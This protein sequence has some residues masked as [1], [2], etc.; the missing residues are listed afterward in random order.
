MTELQMFLEGNGVSHKQ[1]LLRT[2]YLLNESSD[3]TIRALYCI[4]EMRAQIDEVHSLLENDAEFIRAASK[5]MEAA[6]QWLAKGAQAVAKA[7]PM[8]GSVAGG[9]GGA[10]LG[11]ALGGVGAVAGGVGG[12]MGGAKLGQVAGNKLN[13][14]ANKQLSPQT[15]QTPAGNKQMS[16]GDLLTAAKNNNAAALDYLRK[17]AGSEQYGAN[18]RQ[19]AKQ[20]GLALAESAFSASTVIR[21]PRLFEDE[22]TASLQ[23][24][25]DAKFNQ[26]YQAAV[27]KG[28]TPAQ[29]QSFAQQNMFGRDTPSIVASMPAPPTPTPTPVATPTPEA[30]ATAGTP[31]PTAEWDRLQAQGAQPT[32]SPSPEPTLPDGSP[33]FSTMLNQQIG[34]L[35]Q[36][37]PGGELPTAPEASIP[38]MP[39]PP[40]EIEED[41]VAELPDPAPV[42]ME[43]ID[44][45]DVATTVGVD[46]ATLV[47]AIPSVASAA[48][49]TPSPSPSLP[50][51]G[52]D[53]DDP[54]F[55][56]RMAA[57]SGAAEAMQIAES[58]PVLGIAIAAAAGFAALLGL[59]GVGAI[60][61]A[62][63][64]KQLKNTTGFEGEDAKKKISITCVNV[65]KTLQAVASEDRPDAIEKGLAA[66]GKLFYM[67]NGQ[68]KQIKDF[69]SLKTA[70]KDLPKVTAFKLGTAS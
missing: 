1:S 34:K 32:P 3:E 52:H 70:A 40:P 41:P 14:W 55:Q 35:N 48:Q 66:A 15:Q 44:P 42:G 46:P 69:A 37:M 7:L 31:L 2:A 28:Y 67:A 33:D 54:R 27:A 50:A 4:P 24:A 43:E 12:R 9:I 13:N 61:K 6:P 25:M 62:I 47:T 18:I 51:G 23:A 29:A 45:L 10:A 26:V 53:P 38:S 49:P 57:D 5:L 19:W 8:V 65:L 21:I 30:Q 22:S 17:L 60:S 39:P 59:S 58:D 36:A 64:N 16:W 56:S 11:S 68:W 63:K 20:N